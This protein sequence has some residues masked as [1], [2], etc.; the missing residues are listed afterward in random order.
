[1]AKYSIAEIHPLFLFLFPGNGGAG[2]GVFMG[3][4]FEKE[5]PPY[6]STILLHRSDPLLDSLEFFCIFKNKFH[7]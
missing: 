5:E 4:A 2:S 6:L 1:M 7:L 3:N